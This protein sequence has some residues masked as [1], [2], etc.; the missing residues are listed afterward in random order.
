[1]KLVFRGHDDRYAVEQSLLAFHHRAQGMA[2]EAPEAAARRMGA[3]LVQA[4]WKVR[5]QQRGDAGEQH[6]H[7]D[8]HRHVAHTE[9]AFHRAD[10]DGEDV[11]TRRRRLD[12][13]RRRRRVRHGRLWRRAEAGRLDLRSEDGEALYLIGLA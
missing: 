4:G 6:Q 12:G 2:P 5:L 3:S 8:L 1:M 7:A 13:A 9:P 10:S 11:G